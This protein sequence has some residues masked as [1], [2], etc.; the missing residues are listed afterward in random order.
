MWLMLDEADMKIDSTFAPG[1]TR[2]PI[3]YSLCITG[4][5]GNQH[6]A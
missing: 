2:R 6:E 1:R 3:I 4:E 5:V